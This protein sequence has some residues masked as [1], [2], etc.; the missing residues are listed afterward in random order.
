MASNRDRLE[1]DKEYCPVCGRDE[2]VAELDLNGKWFL[3][4][5]GCGFLHG[6]LDLKHDTKKQS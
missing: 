1:Q 4:C 5:L 3:K 6:E 2:K